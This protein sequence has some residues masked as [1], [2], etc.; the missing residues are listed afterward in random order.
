MVFF[1]CER[2]LK[3]FELSDENPEIPDACPNCNEMCTFTD[4]TDYT[5]ETPA[6]DMNLMKK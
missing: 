1:Q 6:I 5:K 2:C 3:V 4:V